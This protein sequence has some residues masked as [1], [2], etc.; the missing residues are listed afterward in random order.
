MH[1][2]SVASA[3]HTALDAVTRV[4]QNVEH[5]AHHVASEIS[6][7]PEHE[8]SEVLEQLA[9]LPRLKQ[10]L[11]ANAAVLRTTDDLL[12]VFGQLLTAPRR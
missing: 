6:T 7:E 10:E 8:T 5:V 12:E 11:R 2:A 9:E 3:M 1:V 4:G